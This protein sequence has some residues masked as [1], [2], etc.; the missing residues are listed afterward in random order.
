MTFSEI[1]FKAI[2]A[3]QNLQRRGFQSREKICFM[4][5]NNENVLPILLASIGLVCPIVPLFPILAKNEIVRILTKIKPHV[6]FCDAELFNLLNEALKE[7]KFNIEVFTFGQ[8][9]DG[10]ES[11]ETL[12]QETG[13]ENTFV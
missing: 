6:V 7:L 8:H 4:T 2:R 10:I 13:E 9:V 3:A 5:I 12:F 1:R 11:V